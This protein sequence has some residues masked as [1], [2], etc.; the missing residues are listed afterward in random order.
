M[1]AVLKRGFDNGNSGSNLLETT[2]TLENVAAQGIKR[3]GTMNIQGDLRGC[4]AQV[5]AMP[6][7][8]CDDGTTRDL[9]IIASM[10]NTVWAFDPNSFDPITQTFDLVWEKK[11]A[12]PVNGNISIDSD[13]INEHWG[14]LSTPVIDPDT[15]RVYLVAWS[16]VDGTP[17]KGEHSIHVLNLKDG[18][19]VC[20]PVPMAGMTSKGQAYSGMMRK[21]RGSLIMTSVA[22]VKTV[23]FGCST[24]METMAGATGWVV[25][26]DVASNTISASLATTASRGAGIWN[27][28]GS[29]CAD[30]AGFL[31]VTSGNGYF[32]GVTNFGECVLKMQYTKASPSTLA[33][34]D[35]W[36]PY[37]DAGR[38]PTP[39]QVDA[40]WDDEDLGSAGLLLVPQHNILVACGKDG[41]GYILNSQNLGKT[42]LADFVNAAGNYGKLLSPPL[43]LTY[44]PGYGVN[45]AP[46]DSS[47]LDFLYQGRAAEMNS[48]PVIYQ[49]AFLDTTLIYVWGSNGRLR[50]WSLSPTGVPT[51]LAQGNEVASANVANG[52]GGSPGG[53]MCLSAN[54]TKAGTAVLWATI[55]YG[56]AGSTVGNGRL[57]AYD[58]EHFVNGVVKVLWDSQAEAVTFIYNKYD[59]PVVSGGKLFVPT[60][61]DGIDVY[62]LA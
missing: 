17:A 36:S 23:F 25:A 9:I 39:A 18:S 34:V 38:T 45:A 59:P 54:G 24:V 27:A 61:A 7:V 51:F 43:W 47:T 40:G 32:D 2:F 58:A 31:Y 12:V 62:A 5:L 15:S 44:F 29:L 49:S 48:T 55:P 26:F 13:L 21:Q 16:S 37:T 28:G 22:G 6:S 42:S 46:Q 14:V 50:V 53:E 11:L 56:D 30:A 4:E 57:L 1:Q 8:T 19:R 60:Y 20:P 3:I 35:W 10:N 33:I 52:G 41:I